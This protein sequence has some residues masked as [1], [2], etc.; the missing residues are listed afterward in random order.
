MRFRKEKYIY[1]K[2]F[3][4]AYYAT[5]SKRHHPKNGANTRENGKIGLLDIHLSASEPMHL[6][7]V[8]NKK[9]LDLLITHALNFSRLKR[10]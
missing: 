8:L 2:S 7:T 6:I 10:I 1:F 4:N 9:F 5:K 3:H